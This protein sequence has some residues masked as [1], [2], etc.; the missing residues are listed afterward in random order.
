MESDTR[1]ER[2]TLLLEDNWVG[3]RTELG[4]RWNDFLAS[5]Q[6]AV[7]PL[8]LDPDAEKLEKATRE[9]SR[10][11]FEEFKAGRCLSLLREGGELVRLI[12]SGVETVPDEAPVKSVANRLVT[13]PKREEESERST[14]D[15]GKPD[16][17][18]H[19]AV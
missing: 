6:S 13:L 17:E 15:D 18:A 9:L 12:G 3:L 1:A 19:E 2:L 8:R 10:L 14:D 5:Y 11:L 7:E 16:N 4:P